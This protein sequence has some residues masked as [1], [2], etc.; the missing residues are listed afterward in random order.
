MKAK[1]PARPATKKKPAHDKR[2]RTVARVDGLLPRQAKFVTEYL[3]TGNAT[4]SALAAGY[5]PKSAHK[6]GQEILQNAVVASHLSHK[7]SEI[8]ARQDE[9]LAKM[10]LTE[11]RIEREI[12]RIAFFDPRK[13]FAPDGRPLAITELDDDTAAVISGLEVL[14]EWEGRGEDRKLVGIVKKYKISDKN[15]ALERAAKI[16]AMFGEDNRQRGDPLLALIKQ[17]GATTIPIVHEDPDQE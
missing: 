2:V 5:S 3:L 4:K 8:A 15:S 6:T 12:A 14:E 13:M 9:R 7:Q 17:L 11:A 16:R 1:K 10:E